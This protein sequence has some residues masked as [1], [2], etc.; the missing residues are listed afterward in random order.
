MDRNKAYFKDGKVHTH[1][2]LA[3]AIRAIGEAGWISAH[4]PYEVNGQQMPLA[5]LNSALM[6]MY[7]ANANA[8]CYPLLTQGDS[9]LTLSFGDEALKDKFIPQMYTGEWQ[10]TM[11]L[12][13]PQAGSS[14]SDIITTAE[15][16]SEGV[17]KIQGQKIY[18]RSR[19]LV[20]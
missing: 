8:A 11:A 19:W 18:D 4:S 16:V 12:T 17:Y 6:V 20:V 15:P 14:L 2:G 3:E 13:E 1:P 5:V 9:N 7:A 10:G